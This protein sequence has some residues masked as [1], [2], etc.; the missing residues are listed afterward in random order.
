MKLQRAG[1]IFLACVFLLLG[2]FWLTAI[3]RRCTAI[4]PHARIV[5]P[6]RDIIKRPARPPVEAK[7]KDNILIK[8]SRSPYAKWYHFAAFRVIAFSE[9]LLALA[10]I[11]AGAALLRRYRKEH[12]WVLGAL[13]GD[14]VYKLAVLAYMHACAVP[15]AKLIKQKNTLITYLVPDKSIFSQ[16]SLYLSGLKLCPPEGNIFY[17]LVYFVFILFC[18]CLF[19]RRKDALK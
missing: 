2:G 12:L 14:V 6:V 5:P 4:S 3:Y 17:G 19:F 15:L 7:K 1:I 8:R 9:V 13:T 11:L 10:F 16:A 18:F